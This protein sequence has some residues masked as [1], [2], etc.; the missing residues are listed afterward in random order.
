MMESIENEFMDN[1]LLYYLE[2]FFAVLLQIIVYFVTTPFKNV[3]NH[4]IINDGRISTFCTMISQL[5]V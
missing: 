3:G 4:H 5:K 1:I 2:T